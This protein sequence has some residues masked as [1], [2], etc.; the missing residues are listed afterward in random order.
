M[1]TKQTCESLKRSKYQLQFL[2][3]YYSCL[4]RE[5][6][7]TTNHLAEQV[8]QWY[9]KEASWVWWGAGWLWE[10]ATT[11][12]DTQGKIKTE[13]HTDKIFT[14]DNGHSDW[15]KN[16][17]AGWKMAQPSADQTKE[18]Q[19]PEFHKWLLLLWQTTKIRLQKNCNK[20]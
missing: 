3:P 6:G 9:W 16:H 13:L 1:T 4:Q 12:A 20:T 7:D 11:N 2:F 17:F 19:S 8:W 14:I 5:G 18:A 15:R 10:G